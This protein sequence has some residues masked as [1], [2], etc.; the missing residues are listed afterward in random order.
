M[1]SRYPNAGEIFWLQEEPENMGPWSFVKGRFYE[2][3]GETHLIHR[4]SRTESG[5][6]ATGSH[7]VHGQEQTQ[8]L[9]TAL[10]P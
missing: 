9:E 8:L 3:H 4:V 1:L 2:A 7:A 10:T 6:P 5:S